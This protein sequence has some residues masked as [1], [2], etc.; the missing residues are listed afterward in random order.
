MRVPGVAAGRH[1]IV[2]Y[3]AEPVVTPLGPAGLPQSTVPTNRDKWLVYMLGGRV[4]LDAI[5]PYV[6]NL[7]PGTT[8]FIVKTLGGLMGAR[9]LVVD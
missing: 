4:L 9:K 8:D 3:L 5:N 2:S 6:V 7:T 1:R